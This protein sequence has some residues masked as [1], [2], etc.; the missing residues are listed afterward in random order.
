MKN[1]KVFMI[2]LLVVPWLTLPLLGRKAFK[3]FLP[4]AI[5]MCTFTKALDFYGEKKNWWKFYNGIGPFDSMNFMNFGAYL[6]TSLW[7]LKLTFGKLP[8]FIISNTLLH[9][10]FIFG[11]LKFV[12]GF[13]IF[14]LEQLTKFQYLVLSF[15]R[16]LILY[17][18]QYITEL[19]PLKKSFFYKKW[20]R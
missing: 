5:F 14:S 16:C 8:L 7:V 9:V 20:I 1:P 19:N 15:F 3:R 13:K 12:D 6:V 18:F 4:T 10:T 11:G 17:A 2:A